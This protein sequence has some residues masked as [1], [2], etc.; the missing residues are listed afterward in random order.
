MNP[1]RI[2]FLN[3]TYAARIILVLLAGAGASAT[4]LS[5]SENPAPPAESE[6]RLAGR[7]QGGVLEE[8][9]VFPADNPWNS[10]VDKLPKHPRSETYIRTIGEDANLHPDFGTE[11]QGA[12]VGI[13]YVVVPPDQPKVSVQF[14]YEDESDKG[15]YPIPPDAPI[16][17]GPNGEGDRH[18]L[19]VDPANRRLYEL[20]SAFP[21]PDGSW[22]A[23]SGA[24]FDLRSND[25]RPETWT[26]A[27][28]A[29]LPIFP[30]LVRYDEVKTGEIDHALRFTARQTRQAYI[31]PARHYASRSSDKDLPPMG[32]R[33]RLRADYDISKF[34]PE[35]QVILRALKKYGMFLADNGGNW[36]ISGA[37]DPRW[38]TEALATLKRIKGRDLEVVQTGPASD[39]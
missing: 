11:W 13:P 37:P 5:Y 15:P 30:G 24:I 27:D 2:P 38:D 10:P 32:L 39:E 7:Q 31:S 26:S 8:L 36:F 33:V 12:P 25:L 35:A 3:R 18:I 22:R 9:Q 23:G 29:G 1:R 17:G 6:G 28:A 16:E 21:N 34:P 19:M 14:Q 4:V 20:F